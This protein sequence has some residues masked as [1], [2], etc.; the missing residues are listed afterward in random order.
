MRREFR[1]SAIQFTGKIRSASHHSVSPR[2]VGWSVVVGAAAGFVASVFR[3]ILQTML[4][5]VM[6]LY[7]YVI[8][9][10]P[11]IVAMEIVIFIAFGW[12]IAAL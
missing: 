5:A 6:H 3:L 4:H 10:R 2:L 12:C 8:P 1:E 7:R 11:W 9:G